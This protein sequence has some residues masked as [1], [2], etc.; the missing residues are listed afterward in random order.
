[1]KIL[2]ILINNKYLIIGA[3][4]IVLW[5]I[6]PIIWTIIVSISPTQN[7]F[8]KPPIFNIN[9]MN[10]K[11]YITLLFGGESES[12]VINLAAIGFRKAYLNTIIISTLTVALGTSLSTIAGYVFS[13]F[14]FFGKK[15]LFLMTIL[16][17]SIPYIVII[18]PLIRIMSFANLTDTHIG[19]VLVNTASVLPL[20]VWFATSYFLTIPHDLDDAS[21]IDGCSPIK[22]F[23]K[24]MIP[25]AKPVIVAN[26]IIIFISSWCSFIIPLVLSSR[27]AKMITL[28]IAELKGKYTFERGLISSAGILAIIPIIIIV[29]FFSKFI[30]GGLAKGAI[31]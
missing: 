2:R 23:F 13:R 29:L 19:L 1:M 9:E 8:S 7:L 4:F 24:I 14:K 22:T 5:S 28:V 21:A 16:S 15:F 17:L 30:I 20:T 3:I 12:T 27:E 26:M 18:I 6:A 31:K 25:L 11:N 10:L